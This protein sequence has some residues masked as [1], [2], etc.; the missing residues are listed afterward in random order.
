M[1]GGA[2]EDEVSWGRGGEVEGG[3]GDVR[4]SPEGVGSGLGEGGFGACGGWGE[5]SVGDCF[6][7]LM[8]LSES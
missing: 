3:G 6:I 1:T 7:R 2:G 4:V 8:T 5:M